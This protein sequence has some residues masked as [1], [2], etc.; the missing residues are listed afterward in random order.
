MY[1]LCVNDFNGSMR[2]RLRNLEGMNL[3]YFVV[4]EEFGYFAG[5]RRRALNSFKLPLTILDGYVLL[6]FVNN[7][8]LHYHQKIPTLNSILHSISSNSLMSYEKQIRLNERSGTS[9][10][11]L[12]HSTLRLSIF[13]LFVTNTVL[14]PN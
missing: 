14:S 10:T 4:W 1:S 2:L 8:L 7:R 12:N 9:R 13:L 6:L 5:E 3:I 11:H